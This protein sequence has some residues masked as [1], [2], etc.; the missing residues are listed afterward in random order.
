MHIKA[1]LISRIFYCLLFVFLQQ[2]SQG[3]LRELFN[4]VQTKP[5]YVKLKSAIKGEESIGY[6]LIELKDRRDFLFHMNMVDDKGKSKLSAKRCKQK[7]EAIDSVLRKPE[8]Q[9]FLMSLEEE[10]STGEAPS[11][12][13]TNSM[14]PPIEELYN[15]GGGIT[16]DGT[17]C[18][19][20]A[21]LQ[22][23]F[24]IH[25]LVAN[26]QM[27]NPKNSTFYGLMLKSI[28]ERTQNHQV[29]AIFELAQSVKADSEFCT[30]VLVGEQNDAVVF[31]DKLLQNID[32]SIQNLFKV[33]PQGFREYVIDFNEMDFNA[34][35]DFSSM[36][37]QKLRDNEPLYD[38]APE[39]LLIAPARRGFKNKKVFFIENEAPLVDQFTLM[40]RVYKLQAVI[41]FSGK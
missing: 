22:L 9:K 15:K 11:S 18:Y 35:Q 28:F 41:V 10:R 6:A 2:Q 39:C 26:L 27:L 12:L 36:I 20:I 7:V 31:C 3:E 34:V 40:K 30:E 17:I 19:M 13:S 25:P 5:E 1:L 21:A 14:Q 29:T 38:R 4:L 37:L 24:H 23:L 16:S 8:A 33:S 32:S